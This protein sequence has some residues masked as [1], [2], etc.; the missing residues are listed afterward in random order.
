MPTISYII[1][2]FASG[3]RSNT[4]KNIILFQCLIRQNNNIGSLCKIVLKWSTL[5]DNS[6][7]MHISGSGYGDNKIN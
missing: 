4:L 1:N 7:A 6:G 2:S 5:I 3:R